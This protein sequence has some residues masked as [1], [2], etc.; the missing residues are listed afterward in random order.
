MSRSLVAQYQ[1]VSVFSVP[2]FGAGPKYSREAKAL[3]VNDSS[4]FGDVHLAHLAIVSIVRIDQPVSFEASEEVP[5]ARADF[6]KVVQPGVPAARGNDVFRI[7]VPPRG[8]VEHLT[9]VVVFRQAVLVFVVETEVARQVRFSFLRFLLL[10]G[11]RLFLGGRRLFL[12]GR[13]LFLFRR[14]APQQG[15][16]IDAFHGVA[17]LAAPVPSDV[18]DLVG[19]RLVQRRVVQDQKT[20]RFV[21][22]RLG[23]LPQRLRVWRP[24]LKQ[25]REGVTRRSGL[26]TTLVVIEGL[27]ARRFGAGEYLLRRNQKVDVVEVIDLR[28]I[29]RRRTQVGFEKHPHLTEL[30]KIVPQLRKP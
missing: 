29:H 26:L 11:R 22:E 27:R 15:Q 2:A 17:M 25:A 19:V 3:Q 21:H 5:P 4:F 16:Q 28:R 10:G 20:A 24:S 23:F 7:K 1:S 9:E 6:L 18:L 14:T 12:G 8:R 30:T 13:R